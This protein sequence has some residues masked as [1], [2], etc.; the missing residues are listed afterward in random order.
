MKIPLLL[1][2]LLIAACASVPQDTSP[3]RDEA[4]IRA[5]FAQAD[6]AFRARDFNQA[7]QLYAGDALL[8]LPGSPALRGS[9]DIRRALLGAFSA[10]AVD[11]A[12]H[13]DSVRVAVSGE[14]AYA[15]GGGVTRIAAVE[16][17]S[18]WVAVL[19]KQADGAWRVIVDIHN[20]DGH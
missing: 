4:A 19:R 16:S 2:A 12:V 3:A 18:K 9:E 20:D 6:R 13:V 7:M 14:M 11:V 17:R 1:S 5:L 8:M 10:P 15:H